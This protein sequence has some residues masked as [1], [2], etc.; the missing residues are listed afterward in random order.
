[1]KAEGKIKGEKLPPPPPEVLP[2]S[3]LYWTAYTYLS[4]RRTY[5]DAGFPHYIQPSEIL[6]YVEL[7]DVY[8]F[9]SRRTLLYVV[10][11]W[12]ETY[13]PFQTERVKA[14][15]AAAARKEAMKARRGQ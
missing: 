11:E 5:N 6:A 1:M 14:Q 3:Q 2:F 15:H 4:A 13:I 12:E 10:S 7:A 9:S 8:N